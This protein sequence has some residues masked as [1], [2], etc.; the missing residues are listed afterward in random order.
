MPCLLQVSHS[1]LSKLRALKRRMQL[2]HALQQ[3]LQLVQQGQGRRARG[4]I[5][6][7]LIYTESSH[8][9]GQANAYPTLAQKFI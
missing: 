6:L 7:H 9:T 5:E 3:R 1:P 8:L 2:A 4:N